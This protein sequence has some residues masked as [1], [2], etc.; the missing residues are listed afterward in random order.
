[1]SD[2]AEIIVILDIKSDQIGLFVGKNGYFIKNKIILPS[3]RTYL[4]STLKTSVSKEDYDKA[5]MACKINCNISA[6]DDGVVS[7]NIQSPTEECNNVTLKN[8]NAYVST[9]NKNTTPQS[10]SNKVTYNFKLLINSDYV[11]KL[12]GIEGSK[13]TELS[14]GI[15]STLNLERNPYIRFFDNGN[16][17]V[18][19]LS[20]KPEID[21]GEVWLSI[22]YGGDKSFVKVKSLLIEFI[23]ETLIDKQEI[24]SDGE[25]SEE[26]IMGGGW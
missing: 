17:K 8:I 6:G 3:K 21:S 2:N 20:F 16:D 11:G 19:T 10:M 4:K 9:F 22:S 12:I 1:M 26:D 7:M 18:E 25:G 24:V 23:N 14:Q 5:W 15:K 13:I